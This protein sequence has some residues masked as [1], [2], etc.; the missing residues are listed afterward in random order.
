[1]IRQSRILPFLLVQHAGFR[2]Q[3]SEMPDM[4]GLN[5]MIVNIGD[6]SRGDCPNPNSR[7]DFGSRVPIFHEIHKNSIHF[8]WPKFMIDINWIKK[9]LKMITRIRLNSG[10][11]SIDSMNSLT[12]LFNA[13]NASPISTGQISIH[14]FL[15]FRLNVITT[16]VSHDSQT[17]EAIFMMPW[18]N[19]EPDALNDFGISL[20]VEILKSIFEM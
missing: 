9:I 18:F 20:N 13:I 10:K 15:Y 4:D 6:D 11:G 14:T 12:S 5:W 3:S 1:M 2:N 7:I 8:H 16:T 19:F 17:R